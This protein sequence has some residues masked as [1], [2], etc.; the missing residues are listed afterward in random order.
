MSQSYWHGQV[1][2]LKGPC[3]KLDQSKR[4]LLTNIVA[5]LYDLNKVI[6]CVWA[7]V[8]SSVMKGALCEGWGPLGSQVLGLSLTL[9]K[10]LSR[11]DEVL[12]NDRFFQEEWYL[13]NWNPQGQAK[14]TYLGF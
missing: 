5:K 7:S 2:E 9:H 12:K 1:W 13:F 8:S 10:F 4:L 3:R 11:Q 6:P 14:H